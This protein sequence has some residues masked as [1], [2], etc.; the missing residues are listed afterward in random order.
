M[1]KL[2]LLGGVIAAAVSA[3]VAAEPLT[4]LS[5]NSWVTANASIFD[6]ATSLRVA[7]EGSESSEEIGE[8]TTKVGVEAGAGGVSQFAE[9]SFVQQNLQTGS[10]NAFRY[11]GRLTSDFHRDLDA[12]IESGVNSI[13][14]ST[15]GNVRVTLHER[16]RL[17]FSIAVADHPE[18]LASLHCSLVGE[19]NG[20]NWGLTLLTS[21]GVTHEFSLELEPGIYSFGFSLTCFGLGSFGGPPGTSQPI[22]GE[23]GASLLATFVPTGNPYQGSGVIRARPL[24]PDSIELQLSALAPGRGY[25]IERCFNLAEP[26]WSHVGSVYAASANAVFVDSMSQFFPSVFNRLRLMP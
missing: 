10:T 17:I 2:L 5:Q 8:R 23:S 3:S 18:I 1:N 7:R 22:N 25:A 19:S 21:S 11:E 13:S 9:S 24:P 26:E 12:T 16:H 4:I 14:L 15:V 20:L 6:D